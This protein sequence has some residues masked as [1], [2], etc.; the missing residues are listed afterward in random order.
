ML[1]A[2]GGGRSRS[3][4]SAT[5]TA[6][7]GGRPLPRVGGLLDPERRAVLSLKPDLVIVYDTQTD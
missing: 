6:S 3:P 4:R 7:A 1:F 2:M 5:T